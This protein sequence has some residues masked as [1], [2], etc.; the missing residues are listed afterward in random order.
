MYLNKNL[1]NN[2]YPCIDPPLFINDEIN[3]K[4]Y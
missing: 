1:L 4:F 3:V 2:R